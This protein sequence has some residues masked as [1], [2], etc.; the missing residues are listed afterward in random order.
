MYALMGGFSVRMRTRRG[1]GGKARIFPLPPRTHEHRSGSRGYERGSNFAADCVSP[2]FYL[3]CVT[4]R[5]LKL[6][7]T[8][9][10]VQTDIILLNVH[11]VDMSVG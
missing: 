1:G 7:S 6:M 11:A 4:R 8:L 9:Y 10:I 2:I 3:M 5:V